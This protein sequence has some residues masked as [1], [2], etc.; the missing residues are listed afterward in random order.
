MKSKKFFD[1]TYTIDNIDFIAITVLIFFFFTMS[2]VLTINIK[3]S[4]E[5]NDRLTNQVEQLN[6]ELAMERE[7]ASS[8]MTEM[9]ACMQTCNYR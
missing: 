5:K 1:T 6:E 8:C 9:N 3:E 4:K 2:C 7:R